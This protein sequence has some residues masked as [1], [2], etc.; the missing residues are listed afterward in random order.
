LTLAR[1]ISSFTTLMIVAVLGALAQFG[2][3]ASTAPTAFSSAFGHGS[4]VVLVHGLGSQTGHWLP[5][6]RRLAHRHRV[7][8]LELPGH[9]IGAMPEPFSLAGATEAFDAALRAASSEPVVLVGHSIGGLVAV[10]EAL[11]HPERVRRLV[12]VETALRPQMIGE[13]R[14]R[15]LHAL[16]TNYRGVLHSAYTA[17][18]RDSAQGESLF[19]GAAGLDSS[20]ITRWIRLAVTADLSQAA[21]S[22]RVPV[23]AVCAERTWPRDEPWSAT[24]EALGLDRVPRLVPVR[25]SGCGH[26]VMLDR[27]AE[28]AT[29]IERF[30]AAPEAGAVARR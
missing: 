25:M 26:F 13:E 18:G 8:L 10:S 21:A 19:A 6:A 11:A 4:T 24:S 1:R 16:E 7:V 20:A 22:L 27:P 23:L 14:A 29:E 2:G 5:V 30:A 3:G 28:L 12:I 9:G 17:F 15:L